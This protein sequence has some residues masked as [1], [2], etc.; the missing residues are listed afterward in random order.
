[1]LYYGK[2]HYKTSQDRTSNTRDMAA[3]DAQR[4]V[5]AL[6]GVGHVST[7]SLVSKN[8]KRSFRQTKICGTDHRTVEQRSLEEHL[9]L[10]YTTGKTQAYMLLS[11]PGR[12]HVEGIASKGTCSPISNFVMRAIAVPFW[13]SENFDS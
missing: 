9:D 11:P 8:H 1:M 4:G 5:K 2:I 3:D 10:P 12:K 13:H 7:I 6:I